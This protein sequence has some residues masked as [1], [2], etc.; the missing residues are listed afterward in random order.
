MCG[1]EVIA[2]E[3]DGEIHVYSDCLYDLRNDIK[4]TIGKIDK[5]LAIARERLGTME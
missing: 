3:V 4:G 5:Y 2:K 1:S